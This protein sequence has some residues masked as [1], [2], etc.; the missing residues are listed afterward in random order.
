[1]YI[2]CRNMVCCSFLEEVT[3]PLLAGIKEKDNVNSSG[4]VGSVTHTQKFFLESLKK[5]TKCILSAEII[6][7]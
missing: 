7:I 3:S 6:C 1:M 2:V 4:E 5:M